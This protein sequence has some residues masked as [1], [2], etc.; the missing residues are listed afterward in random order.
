MAVFW[1]VALCSLV[2]DPSGRVPILRAVFR[3]LPG[4]MAGHTFVPLLETFGL[5]KQT[6][7]KFLMRLLL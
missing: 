2:R 5:H 1:V 6:E 3:V 7:A 4:Y